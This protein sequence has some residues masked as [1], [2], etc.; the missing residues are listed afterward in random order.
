MRTVEL[1]KKLTRYLLGKLTGEERIE[2]EDRYLSDGKFFDE[3][4]VAED[5]LIDD[6]VRGELSHSNRELF[7]RNF[8]C[9]TGRHERVK[10]ARAL[11]KFADT[12]A[13]T[14]RVSWW[15]RVRSALSLESPAMRLVLATGFMML[16]IGGPLVVIQMSKLSSDLQGLKSEQ[17]AQNQRETELEQL[18]A[19]Q[20]RQNDELN[21][22]I[23]RERGERGQL[24]QEVARLREQQAP[25]VTFALGFGEIER[26]K[27]GPAQATKLNVPQ[28]IEIIKLQLELLKDE[29]ENYMVILEDAQQRDIWRGL[30][31]STKAGKHRAV[32]V[33]L[34]SRLLSTGQYKLILSGTNNKRDYEVLSEFN[35]DVIKK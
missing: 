13:A 25:P 7:E 18:L 4:A 34:P 28:G 19:Q 26:S 35:V 21:Q 14:T 17:L 29:Y 3:L 8:L 10:S 12:H 20:K 27:G 11:M 22:A 1:D 16:I 31:Q 32:V 24:E 30:L 33:R 15:Q 9:S 5:E 2:V 6:Y 23:N